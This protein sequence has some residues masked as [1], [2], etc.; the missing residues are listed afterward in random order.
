MAD[1]AQL[2]GVSA[3]TVSRALRNPEVV[4]PGTLK[5]IEAAIERTGYLPN[6]IAGSLSS[7][8]TNVLGLIVPSLRNAVFVE[9]IRGVADMLGPSFDLMIAHSGYTLKGEE[10]AVVAFLSQRVCG[11][12][13]HNTRHTPRTLR[14]IHEVAVPCV[15]MGNLISRPIDMAVGF[16]NRDAARAMSED[17]ILQGYRRIGFVSLPLKEND[18]ASERRAGYL[19][20]LRK[21][22]M[23]VDRY[24]VLEAEPGLKSGGEALVRLVEGRRKVDAVFLTGDVLATG[25]LLEANRRGWNVPNDIAIAA[26]DD[27]ELQENVLPPLTSIRFP[28]YEIGRR[29]ASMVMDRVLGRSS[30][31][32][33]LDLGFEI[34]RRAST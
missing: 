5:R 22:R 26:S 10:A 33:I 23:A 13:L 8:R 25:A 28:R 32:A 4:T 30:G 24:I 12:I 11:L 3:M 19:E 7:Q 1:V 31:S 17:L 21:H 27:D 29:A 16:S 2:A 9:T 34:I 6:R 20:A 15:E 18:R 14:L